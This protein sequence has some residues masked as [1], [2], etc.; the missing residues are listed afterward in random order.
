MRSHRDELAVEAA[1]WKLVLVEFVAGRLRTAEV[2]ARRHQAIVTAYYGDGTANGSTFPLALTLAFR[3]QLDEARLLAEDE[4]RADPSAAPWARAQMEGV[5]GRIEL[6]T[7]SPETACDHFAAAEERLPSIEPSLRHWRV[8][9]V[10][11]LL[12]VDR[13][14]QA[15]ELLDNWDRTATRLGR[16]TVL[17]EVCRCRGRGSGPGRCD[18]SGGIAQ[19]AAAES[20]AVGD[21]IGRAR[22]LLA[23][24]RARRRT[25]Q[26]RGSRD[27]LQ[28]AADI[29]HECGAD[30]LERTARAELSSISGRRRHEGL[31][32]AERRVADLAAE[33][34]TNREVA[35]ELFLSLSTVETHLSHVYAK[36]G[37]RSRTELARTLEPH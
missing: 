25:K 29:F 3:G 24:G 14:A 16:V 2:I 22:A 27:A 8:E 18:R 35:A 5:L 23:L 31:T 36:L 11:A 6:W 26:K 1:M 17:A 30:G 4:F 20:A 15:V 7:G 33:G 34:R 12:V 32:P 21:P 37:I 10:E 28:F 13:R 19:R 9:Y